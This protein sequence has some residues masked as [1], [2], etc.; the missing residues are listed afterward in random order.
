M[1]FDL[2]STP[3]ETTA[4][5]L[6]MRRTGLRLGLLFLS[7]ILSSQTLAQTRDEML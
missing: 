7:S 4:L 2:R 6:P 1:N 5:V 3:A